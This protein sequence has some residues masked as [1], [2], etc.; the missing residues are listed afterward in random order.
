M[1]ILQFLQHLYVGE[2]N[3]EVLVDRLER[4][5]N[6]DVILELHCYFLVHQSFEETAIRDVIR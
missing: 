4:A 1:W 2:L 6:G 5:A 3:V